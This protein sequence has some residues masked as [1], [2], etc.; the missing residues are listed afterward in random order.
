M[1][2]NLLSKSVFLVLFIF[3]AGL[4]QAAAQD[5][6]T[7]FV[8][9]GVFWFDKDSGT[10]AYLFPGKNLRLTV[11]SKKDVKVT[12]HTKI[13]SIEPVEKE[14]SPAETVGDVRYFDFE[15]YFTKMTIWMALEFT[16]DGR[17]IPALTRTFYDNI[18]ETVEN[19][20]FFNP[21]KKRTN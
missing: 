4:T 9:K 1:L 14:L 12:Y 20:K 18:F 2:F 5:A 17:K 16:V 10:E 7:P 21:S 8:L 11:I 13:N 15:H 19:E 3:C 6:K